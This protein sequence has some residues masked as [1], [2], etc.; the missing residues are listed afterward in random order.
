MVEIIIAA[1]PGITLLLEMYVQLI[2]MCCW[3]CM[4]NPDWNFL[5]A[6]TNLG[7]FTLWSLLSVLCLCCYA[8]G[9][10]WAKM[11]YCGKYCN[12]WDGPSC[13]TVAFRGPAI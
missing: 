10:G 7:V 13:Y 5:I 9:L 12:L 2:R 11:L 6:A 3:R 4:C 1:S 8:Q